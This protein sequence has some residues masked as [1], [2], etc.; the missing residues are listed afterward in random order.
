MKK[1]LVLGV[2]LSL[3]AS[4]SVAKQTPQGLVTDSR[5]KVVPYDSN[6]VVDIHTSYGYA[7]TIVL[8]KGEYVTLDGG[9]GKKAGWK[10]VSKPRSNFI[11]IKPELKDNETNFNFQT[12]KNR[13]YSLFLKASEN[14][15]N[16]TYMVRFDYPN[17]FGNS[18]FATRSET[19]KMIENFGNPGEINDSYSFSGDTTIAPVKAQDNGTFTLLRFRKG[20]PIPAILAVDPSTRKESLVNFRVQGDYVVVEGV[21]VQMT[22]RYGAHVTCLFND[23]GVAEF[24][25]NKP[26]IRRIKPRVV[27]A[28]A[29]QR[30]IR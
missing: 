10:I 27:F 7:T 16:P 2:F 30:P 22:L 14:L 12:N 3:I 23:K 11:I 1:R 6:N 9:I 19:Y 18:P 20:T 5:I 13:I 21:Y 25:A 24:Y 17:Q 8:E 4:I 29:P 15:R 26:G 28:K